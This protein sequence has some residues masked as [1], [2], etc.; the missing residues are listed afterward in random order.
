MDDSL[1]AVLAHGLLN[2]LTVVRGGVA[3][4]DRVWGGLSEGQRHEMAEAALAQAELMADG[5]EA[6]P[7]PVR[8]RLASHLFVVRGV[9][10]TLLAEGRHLND[11]DRGH[12]VGVVDRQSASAAV[13][14]HEIVQGLPAEVLAVL[15]GLDD[16]RQE[17]TA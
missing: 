12:L 4:L 7:S 6:L 3:M 1:A 15:N 14:L 5:L 11:A 10:H 8:H 16:D 2:S 17:A 13:V 9:C